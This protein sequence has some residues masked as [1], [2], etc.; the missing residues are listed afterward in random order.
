[1]MTAISPPQKR[2]QFEAMQALQRDGLITI[3]HGGRARVAEP[4]IGRM[5]DPAAVPG[6]ERLTVIEHDEIVAA[7]ASGQPDKAA[8]A[9]THHL[10]RATAL[11]RCPA[12][13]IE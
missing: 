4:S 10:I 11:N 2:K 8:M 1:M 13:R 7:I 9:M 12:E 3:R 5:F 6:L